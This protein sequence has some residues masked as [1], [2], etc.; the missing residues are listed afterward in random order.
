[1]LCGC[2]WGSPVSKHRDYELMNAVAGSSPED[3]LPVWSSQPLVP[4]IFLLPLLQ[5]SLG[6]G[7]CV[8]CCICS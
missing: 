6:L 3:T 2:H 7:V 1:M 8:R 5:W 4:T